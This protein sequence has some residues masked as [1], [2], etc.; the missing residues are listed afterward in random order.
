MKQAKNYRKKA[1]FKDREP[2]NVE[3]LN[4]FPKAKFHPIIFHEIYVKSESVNVNID[5]SVILPLKR[6]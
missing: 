3:D 4:L 6:E 1:C 5:S 2:L